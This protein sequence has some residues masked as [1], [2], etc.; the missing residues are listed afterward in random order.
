MKIALVCSHGGHL[1][2]MLYLLDAFKGHEIF[3]ISYESERTNNLGYKSFLFP[4]F[5]EKP[6]NMI[7]HFPKIINILIK[8]RPSLLVSN[9]AEIALPFFY[10]AKI[11]RIKTVFIEC[12]TRI[13]EPTITGKLVYPIADTF[14]VF[15]PEML[16]KY[17]KKAQ[18]FGGLFEVNHARD[19]NRDE[20]ENKLFVTVGMHYQGFDRLV[21][22]MDM[23]ADQLEEQ[24]IMQIGNTNY[25]PKRAE[26]F[27][28]KDYDE[29][30]EIISKSKA[31]ICQ[32]AMSAIDSLVLGV[33]VIVVPRSRKYGEII[34]DHQL[35]FARKLE[36]IGL[37][38]VVEEIKELPIAV[39]RLDVSR[40]DSIII[41]RNFID[42]IK[43]ISKDIDK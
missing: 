25:T 28:F 36:E 34:N 11:L 26:F 1:T 23:I 14:I 2:E 43:K 8:E 32:G 37:V 30:K 13:D 42:S 24:I 39:S 40:T 9:G 15:W 7:K 19:L 6:A 35:I 27:R 31:V 29:I 21:K 41:N 4:N 38:D 33:P 16:S 5:G 12:Y 17:G 10:A 22:T 18:F 3:F 20:K